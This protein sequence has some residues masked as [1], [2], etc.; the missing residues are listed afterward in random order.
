MKPENNDQLVSNHQ[1]LL[2]RSANS[3]IDQSIIDRV[4]EQVNRF[5]EMTSGSEK[6]YSLKV[7]VQGR[8]AV[9]DIES[10]KVDIIPPSFTVTMDP[11]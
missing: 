3:I 2:A 6:L 8:G 1:I 10:N 9:I 11:R 7:V 4:A 5:Y